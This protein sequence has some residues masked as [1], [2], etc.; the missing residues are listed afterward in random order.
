MR[1]FTTGFFFGSVVLLVV[2]F[3]LPGVYALDSATDVDT[4]AS[5][6]SAQGS[7]NSDV[8]NF[9][10]QWTLI[11]A[12]P[13]WTPRAWHST[14]VVPDGSIIL[15]GGMDAGL[16]RK[17]DVWRS[18]D[19]GTTWTQ[20]N[21]R[22]GWSQRYGQTCVAME[23]GSIV[24][25][26]GYENSRVMNDVWMS[27]DNGATWTQV[28][29]NAPWPARFG[30]TSVVMQDGSIILMGGRNTTTPTNDVWRSTDHGSTWMLVTRNAPWS[31]RYS[32]GCQVMP[33][34]SIVLMGGYEGKGSASVKGDTWRSTDMGAS[35]TLMNERAWDGRYDFSSVVTLEGSIILMSGVTKNIVNADD[36]WKSDDNGT[37]WTRIKTGSLWQPRYGHSSVITPDGSIIIMGGSVN[38]YNGGDM[39][40]VWRFEPVGTSSISSS[41]D[42]V[43]TKEIQPYS[44]KEGTDGKITITVM[45]KGKT[46]VHD[47]EILDITLPEF[48]VTDGTLRYSASTIEP[49]D[50]RILTYTVHATKAG[51]YRF[52]K[53][54]VMYSGSDGNYH[55]VY[56]GFTKVSVLESLFSQGRQTSDRGFFQSLADWFSRL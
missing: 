31:A 47:V 15:M 12:N 24:L 35:W 46:P 40:D 50:S 51:S 32:S 18:G 13:G 1:P 16:G 2:A 20:M 36:I 44:L 5:A 21:A 22:S 55:R 34:D 38:G 19:N 30:H 7:G 4:S 53:T 27:K 3:T 54:T 28:T 42:V 10:G 8:G 14:V 41:N 6:I 45:N 56:S 37:T 43:V 49:G 33:D 52:D 23:D 39:H 25:M 11:N 48:P 9:P 29:E 17:N 26:G